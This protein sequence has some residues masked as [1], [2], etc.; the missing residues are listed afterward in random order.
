MS[1]FLQ[2]YVDPI[3]GVNKV[4]VALRDA[5]PS[6]PSHY[7]PCQSHITAMFAKDYWENKPHIM[8][9]FRCILSKHSLA[10]DHQRKVVKRTLGDNVVGH[11]GQ[12]FT[13]CGSFGVY[14]G[15]DTALFVDEKGHV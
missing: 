10:V 14:V 7:V 11:S 9:E 15:L 1:L 13:I 3:C 6:F 12:T 5:F 2:M 4:I 8:Y